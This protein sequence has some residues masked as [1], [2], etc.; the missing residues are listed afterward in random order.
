MKHQAKLILLGFL[1]LTMGVAFA[2]PLLVSELDVKPFIKHVQGPT[3]DFSVDVVY[4]NFT[5]IHGSKPVSENDGPA[6]SYYVVLNI[7]NLSDIGAKLLHVGFV[8][9]RKINNMSSSPPSWLTNSQGICGIGYLAE[10]AWVDGVWYNVTLATND[11]PAVDPQG[12]II[13]FFNTTEFEDYWTEGVQL[14]DVYDENGNHKATYM[15][16]NGT[17]TN[18]TGRIELPQPMENNPFTN[19][20]TISDTVVSLLHVFQAPMPFN[21]TSI[22]PFSNGTSSIDSKAL[23]YPE[24]KYTWVGEGLF[25]NYWAPRQSRLIV[26]QGI[27]NITKS[28]ASAEALEALKSG[29]ISLQT[30]VFNHA[31]VTVEIVNNTAMDTWSYATELKQVQLARNGDSYIYNTILGENQ[32]FITDQYGV[33]AFIEERHQP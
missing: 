14:L 23:G 18:V 26:L 3:A 31:D 9:A 28:W 17:W 29:S 22:T 13:T 27:Q 4:A 32:F 19:V 8:A 15:N 6:I 24:T 21:N 33:E 16:M 7:T 25:D 5:I 20:V 2:S 11:W 10:G 1:S 30:R 12:N